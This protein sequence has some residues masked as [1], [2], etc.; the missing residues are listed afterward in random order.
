[1][2]VVQCDRCGQIS[3][4]A[5]GKAFNPSG[6]SQAPLDLCAACVDSY[7]TWVA[8][9]KASITTPQAIA[10]QQMAAAAASTTAAPVK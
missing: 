9:G 1:M 6:N 3:T 10:F 7:K 2:T 8:G 4:H 5:F